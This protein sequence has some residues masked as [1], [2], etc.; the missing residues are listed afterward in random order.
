MSAWPTR[1]HVQADLV[2]GV[3]DSGTAHAI[4]YANRSGIPFARPFIKYTPTWPRSFMPQDQNLRN[5]IARMKIIPIDALIREQAAAADRRL[6]R[7]RHPAAG[8]YRI[9]LP[10]RRQGSPY[11]AG[12]P[13]AAVR[14]PLPEFLP[15]QF[16]PGPD[17]PP[18]HRR[19]RRQ[20]RPSSKLADYANPESRE[21]SRD[22]RRHLQKTE[23]HIAQIQPPG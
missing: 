5:L 6:D 22:G 1:D 21:L 18:G 2:A 8:N 4:G 7:P 10:V 16:D 19:A 20:R 13:A 17:R 9:S 12:L 11:P 14:L 23:F 15:G 3:P